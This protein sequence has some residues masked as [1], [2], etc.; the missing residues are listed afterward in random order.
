MKTKKE[1]ISFILNHFTYPLLNYW[2]RVYGYALK[3]KIWNMGF[4]KKTEDFIFEALATQEFY[5]R[6]N[7]T[8][9]DFTELL[10]EKFKYNNL[11]IGSNGRNGGY[12]VLYRNRTNNYANQTY[13]E[14]ELQEMDSYEIEEIYRLLKEFDKLK[15]IIKK[16]CEYVAKHFKVKE[17][18]VP[19]VKKERVLQEI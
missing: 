2:N 18:E 1:L 7:D 12:L 9:G 5:D 8:I 13:E 14:Y 16:E 19:Y 15:V 4:D 3:V 6:L 10:K 11:S 17:V